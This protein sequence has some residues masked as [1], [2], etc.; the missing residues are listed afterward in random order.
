MSRHI[1]TFESFQGKRRNIE[2]VN[3][4]VI[5]RDSS[6][7]VGGIKVDKKTISAYAK[8]VKDQ[9]SKDIKSMYSEMEIA[10]ELVKWSVNSLENIDNVPVS[11]LMGGEEEMAQDLD[12][13]DDETSFDETGESDGEMSMED[14][15]DAGQSSDDLDMNDE[16][17][18]DEELDLDVDTN[19]D[20]FES[21]DGEE[22]SD[23]NSDEESDNLDLEDENSDEEEDL[24]I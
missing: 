9:T 22:S 7:I 1:R 8:K 6:F 23:E 12:M 18:G 19:L 20:D 13:N 3:E 24:P 10:E 11:A 21:P 4:T 15:S 17:S 5:Q 16:E 2:T 14:D